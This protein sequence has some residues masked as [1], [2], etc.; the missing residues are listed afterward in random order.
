MNQF[1]TESSTVNYIQKE[2]CF[3]CGRSNHSPDKCFFK[4]A[5][6]HTCKRRGHIKPKCPEKGK[7]G[8]NFKTQKLRKPV[9]WKKK[10]KK[11]SRIKFVDNQEQSSESS[12]SESGN[13]DQPTSNEY[14][15]WNL[16]LNKTRKPDAIIIQI[17]INDTPCKLELDTGAAATNTRKDVERSVRS[18][19]TTEI[20]F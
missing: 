11:N 1:R 4:D 12:E 7:K 6:C 17:T 13:S 15:K 9:E 3:R 10:K 16:S 8:S 20:G 5:E 14:P 2:E 18:N 19:T